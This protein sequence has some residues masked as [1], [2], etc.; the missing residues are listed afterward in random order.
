MSSYWTPGAIR[1]VEPVVLDVAE[2]DQQRMLLG[3]NGRIGDPTMELSLGW[4][5]ADSES[6]II[7]STCAPLETASERRTRAAHVLT[8]MPPIQHSFVDGDGPQ[9][10]VNSVL[11]SDWLPRQLALDAAESDVQGVVTDDWWVV[12]GSDS[13]ATTVAAGYHVPLGLVALRYVVDWRPYGVDL[14]EPQDST[15]FPPIPW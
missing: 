5:E 9:E 15:A 2:D 6:R 14:S 3:M 10:F 12:V 1:P 11:K 7:V 13:E 8:D 4:R